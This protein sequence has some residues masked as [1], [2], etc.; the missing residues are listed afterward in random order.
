MTAV[1]N[2]NLPLR[3]NNGEVAGFFRLSLL[4]GAKSTPG[5][6]PLLDLSGESLREADVSEV[7]LLEGGEYRYEVLGLAQ[8]GVI[9]TDRPEV[10]QPDTATGHTGRVRPGL[11]IG[12]LPVAAFLND[13]E[14]GRFVIEVRSR[15]LGYRSEYRWMLRDI[16]QQMTE[17][18]MDRFAVAEQA[19]AFDDTRDAVTLY[20]R[21]AF[22]KSL[23]ASEEFGSALARILSTPHVIWRVVEESVDAGRGIKADS[24]VARQLSRAGLRRP[25][26]GGR[27][28]T[29]PESLIRRRTEVSTNN[30][31]NRFVKFA[32][33]RWRTV[34]AHIGTVLSESPTT[35]A[36]LRGVREVNNLLDQLDALLAS[37]LF[38]EVEELT[39][40]PA[41]DQVLQKK[42]GYRDVY[43]AYIQFDVAS[44]LGWSG[45]EDAYGAGQRDVA[46][47]YEYWAFLVLAK[48]LSLVLEVPF[49]L[50]R[51]VELSEGGL[52]VSL[53]RGQ[54]C[55]LYGATHRYGRGLTVE[56]WF[57]K[58]FSGGVLH[59]TWTRSMR[60]DYS[61]VVR[62][63]PGETASFEPVVLHFDAK[64]RV[65]FISD[66][67][68]REDEVQAE[69]SKGTDGKKGTAL[70]HD[71]L[72]M[73]AY[74]D[75]IR[76]SV[77]AYVLYPGTELEVLSEYHEILPGLGAFALRPTAHGAAEGTQEL[78]N[79]LDDAL[80]HVALQISQHER[81]RYW[82]R[83]VFAQ[84]PASGVTAPPATFLS[85]PPADTLVLLGFVRD[86][87]HW[88][89]ID[90]TGLYN[91]RAYEAEGTVGLG[92][93]QLASEIV[94]LSCPRLNRVAIYKVTKDPVVRTREQMLELEYPNPGDVYFCFSIDSLEEPFWESRLR[95]EF[96]E[97]MRSEITPTVG[98]PVAVSWL[99]LVT[100]LASFE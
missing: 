7:Q 1:A 14:V 54:D 83:K 85:A 22:L 90:R 73:H 66:L 63:G 89:W 58:T 25:W 75:A 100:R 32:L 69:E 78:G 53:R 24:R 12:S 98:A 94:V 96:I 35:P 11:H 5:H 60:P 47:L 31:P 41:D 79:F 26:P 82:L 67:F 84:P 88:E 45:G 34:V 64:Y 38:R 59:G 55:V 43:R 74:R 61:I 95:C 33:R 20:E 13:R 39:R 27:L 19:F 91:L 99:E 8:D 81:G 42:E 46:T 23:I 51:L 92:S 15:K 30:T 2:I 21:F 93:K 86:E 9:S 77:G 44:K 40:F 71:L 36:V 28:N 48:Q 62:P 72:K 80:N 29:L 4:P 16:A 3:N 56:L 76:R 70:R 37:E 87:K 10:F 50:A 52:N 65:D 17:I 6:E 57:N 18:V 49:D 97:T 68:G